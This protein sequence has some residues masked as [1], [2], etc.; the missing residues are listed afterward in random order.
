MRERNPFARV[1]GREIL[2]DGNELSPGKDSTKDL[3]QKKI[4][5]ME[6]RLYP[7]GCESVMMVVKESFH[8]LLFVAV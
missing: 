4:I 8:V 3:R 7:S 6:Y 1:H 5:G 2:I